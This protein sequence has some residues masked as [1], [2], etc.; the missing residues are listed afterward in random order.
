MKYIVLTLFGLI[1]FFA[2]PI[3]F[4][5]V[6][7]Q[8]RIVRVGVVIDG[9]WE[10][11]DQIREMTQR[12]ILTLTEGEFDVRFPDS[13]IIIADWTLDGV[14]SATEQLLADPEIDMVLTM[15][16]LA[17]SDVSRRANLP[18][19]V[20]APFTIDAELQGLPA[21]D[22][23]TGVKNLH[24]LSRPSPV[25]RDIQMFR[26]IVPFERVLVLMNSAVLQGVPELHA[27]FAETLQEI[28][29]NSTIAAVERTVDSALTQ[30]TPQTEAVYI[31]PLLHLQPGDFQKLI[32]TL[33]ERKIPSFSLLGIHEVEQ[34]VM[35]TLGPDIFPN[36]TRRIALNVQR[37]L[38]GEEPADIPTAFAVGE[39][40]TINMATARAV[41][42][43]PPFS[44]LTEAVLINEERKTVERHLNLS[45]VL[46]EAIDKNLDLAAEGHF[47][48]ASKQNINI[49]RSN[50]LPQIDLSATGLLIDD[51]RAAASLGS[52]AER[53]LFA[54][55]TLTQLIFSESA[56]ANFS[57][58]KELQKN[59]VEQLDQLRQDI[60]QE[61]A[62]AYLDVLRAKTF[63]S[64]QKENLKRTRENFELAKVRE[65]IGYSRRSEVYRWESEIANDR[66]DVISANAQRNLAEI[67]LN[68]LLHQPLEEPFLTDEADLND[69]SLSIS[70]EGVQNYYDDPLSFKTFRAFLVDEGLTLSPELRAIDAVVA[71]KNRELLS[72]NLAFWMPTVA[73]QAEVSRLLKEGGAGVSGLQL[74]PEVPFLIPQADDTDWSVALNVSIPLS[75][76]GNRF[77]QRS[78]AKQELQELNLRRQSLAELVEQ[79]IRSALHIAGASRAGIGLTRSAADAA[80]KNLDFVTDAYSRGAV[81]IIDLLD[82]QNAAL[83]AGLAAANAVYDFLIDLVEVERSVGKLYFLATETERSAMGSRLREYFQKAGVQLPGAR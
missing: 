63:E 40:L 78:R 1:S 11:N 26:E 48:S 45:K 70:G 53:T 16:V 50:L 2:L 73:L 13:K 71:A 33:I 66:L 15:G 55:G 83:N 43:S 41:G 35:A 30:L 81:D 5:P 69:P 51:D 60:G 14:R 38:L 27:R 18:K 31:A 47:V 46:Q 75:E 17:S 9:P 24:Y 37:I 19:P 82:A 3:F 74:P 21:K 42:V 25:A 7:S 65:K 8:N 34:G 56:W 32:D 79:R 67:A 64:V 52:Q 62:T 20:V 36:F 23:G 39:R 10:R 54:G 59:R 44:V 49:A 12:E 72:T 80:K 57:I 76:G 28:G 4:P 29:V 58:Q 68:R 61:A 22:G 6:F 77:A